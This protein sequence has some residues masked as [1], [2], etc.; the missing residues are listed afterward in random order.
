MEAFLCLI[1]LVNLQN[2]YM[3]K[4]YA[5]AAQIKFLSFKMALSIAIFI[6]GRGVGKSFT[7]GLSIYEMVQMFPGAKSYLMA[8]T[9]SQLLT[10]TL[11]EIKEA[12]RFLNLIENIHY[13]I[14]R[15]PPRNFQKSYKKPEKWQHTMTFL[16]GHI[17]E[18]LSG[19]RPDLNR[20]GGYIGGHID[21][22]AM[23]KQQ[24]FRTVVLP[25][26]R[27]WR[28]KYGHQPMFEMHRFF[29]SMPWKPSGYWVLDYE[30]KAKENP[31][32]FFFLETSAIENIALL[33]KEWFELRKAEMTPLEY[34]V[35]IENKRI[36]KIPDGF[37]HKFD[38]E[39]HCY[40]AAYN[41][42]E[43]IVTGEK[44]VDK[45]Q[46]IDFSLDF[47][48]KFQCGLAIQT[49]RKNKIKVLREFFVKGD[50]KI[51]EL[52]RN[53]CKH[54]KNHP[55]K[56]VNVYGEPRGHDRQADGPSHYQSIAKY[57]KSH[58]WHCIIKA[59]PAVAK[60]HIERFNLISEILDE[61]N[62]NLPRLRVNENHCMN[63]IIAIQTTDINPDFTKNKAKEKDPNFPQEHAPH[64]PDCIDN[65]ITQRFSYLLVTNN[66]D[67]YSYDY[68]D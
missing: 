5:N 17:V 11:P 16:N 19:D 60:N 57:F 61:D 30:K 9:Y 42:D 43:I 4:V 6:G 31:K 8:A 67:Y 54:Y 38:D 26:V 49:T 58:G 29:T 47:S 55:T 23:I 14:G 7:C 65:Y 27:G 2:K 45:N 56:I 63:F 15:Q 51:K 33:G 13:V 24:T 10:K 53:F 62:P 28:I 52:V 25:A 22:V 35:E 68:E 1:A 44:D 32:K 66:Y 39:K 40:Q 18:F 3:K 46:A 34:A 21:E 41:Y 48:G 20:G 59:T 37:Y 50:E 36:T 12:L 64:L